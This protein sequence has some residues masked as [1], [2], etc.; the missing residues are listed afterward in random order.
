L[1]NR[2]FD[3]LA[4]DIQQY[5]YLSSAQVFATLMM[6]RTNR[7]DMPTRNAKDPSAKLIWKLAR[8][9][10]EYGSAIG[11]S[12]RIAVSSSTTIVKIM[13]DW[14]ALV[15]AAEVAALMAAPK[16]NQASVGPSEFVD[17]PILSD[18]GKCGRAV[19][20]L[21]NLTTTPKSVTNCIKAEKTPGLV[22]S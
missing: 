7:T 1:L 10:C 17:M 5:W 19:P 9:A 8:F 16:P 11:H 4:Q 21:P 12:A 3:N 14:V 20:I 22:I 13:K 18:L 15:A 6:G 2:F